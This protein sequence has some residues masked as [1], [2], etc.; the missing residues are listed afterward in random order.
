MEKN[1]EK[2][3]ARLLRRHRWLWVHCLPIVKVFL[4]LHYGPFDFA[5]APELEGGY[6]VLPNH[7]C[8]ADQFFVAFS[9]IKKHMYYVASEHAFRKKLLGAI[10]RWTTGPISR[11]KGTV[12]ASTVLSILRWLRQGVPICI[13]PEGNRTWDGRSLPLHPT[14]AKLLKTAGVPVVTYRIEGG[15]LTDPRWSKTLRRGRLRGGVVHVYPPEELKKMS[16]PEINARISADL[17]VDTDESQSR[18]HIPYKGKRL[19]EG[20]EEALFLCPKCGGIGTL[21]GK[22]SVFA[23]SC[24]LRAVYGEDGFFDEGAPFRSVAQWDDWQLSELR[25]RAAELRLVDEGAELWQIGEDHRETLVASGRV[26]LDTSGLRL[27]GTAFTL[28]EMG[29]PELCH[30]AGKET[31][32]FSAAGGSYE[33]RFRGSPSRRK[34]QLLLKELP[35]LP[36]AGAEKE[37]DRP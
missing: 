9:F 11:V 20:L 31:M 29:E 12:A 35:A 17:W 37:G 28:E 33:L 2:E 34:Y 16:L 6:I 7:S 4:R 10:M 14:T 23:C 21:H 30:L 1:P 36:K 32:M 15:Y 25:R 24:G 18:E 19:A 3:K 26:E 27:G 5:P 13:F 8:G 22:G